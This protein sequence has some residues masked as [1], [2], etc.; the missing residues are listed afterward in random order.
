MPLEVEPPPPLR[1]AGSGEVRPGAFSK[2]ERQDRPGK[3]AEIG[4]GS[5]GAGPATQDRGRERGEGAKAPQRAE[6][7]GREGVQGDA[8]AR[9]A[10]GSEQGRR[11]AGN[12]GAGG[13]KKGPGEGGEGRKD[14]G[15]DFVPKPRMT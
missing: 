3:E 14:R 11:G 2:Q 4:E 9:P 5:R 10:G 8:G 13:G 1:T 6:S 12:E 7:G 15:T